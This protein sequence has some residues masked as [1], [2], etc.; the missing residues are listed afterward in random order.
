MVS[1]SPFMRNS[2]RIL[3]SFIC[4]LLLLGGEDNVNA[5]QTTSVAVYLPMVSKPAEKNWPMAAAN[6]ERTSW[7]PEEVRGN[8]KPLWYKPFKPYILPRV[9]IIAALGNL[10]VS[11]ARGLYALDADTGEEKWVYP[12]EL[13]LGHSPTIQD[14]I[15][16]VGGFDRKIYAINALTGEGLW[17]FQAGA[18]FDT[19]PLVVNGILYAG[20][21]D[22]FFY[23]IHING[24]DTGKL[25]WKFKTEGPIHFSAA[26]K[27]GTVYFASDDSYTYALDA[28]TGDLV[29]KSAK[30][31]GAGFHSWWP[32]VNGDYVIFAGSNNYRFSSD[33]G[34][35]S[36][37]SFEKTV[38]YP[39]GQTDP[40]GTL[41]GP[42]G[43]DSGAW[44]AGTPTI[45]T[46]K[47]ETTPNGAT[48][49][50][51]E[52]FEQFPWRRTYFVL[53]RLTGQ[54][55]T[56]DFD[57]DGK[58]EYAPILWYGVKGAGN[59]YPPIV[60]NDNILYQTNNYMSDPAIAGGQISG[61]QIGTPLISVITSDWGAI[62]EPEA[63]SAGGN[64]IYWNLCCDRQSG[65]IDISLPDTNFL[66][67]YNN[68]VRPPTGGIDSKR[69]GRYFTYNL[70]SIL[71]GYNIMYYG[72][73]GSSY[74][75]FGGKNGVY[76]YHGDQNPPIPYQGKVYMH[77][78]NAVIAFAPEAQNPIG[79]PPAEIK[80]V[81]SQSNPESLDQLQA[82]L[83]AEVE[84]IL[85]AGH[86]RPGYL[87]AG[88]FDLRGEFSC[89]DDLVDYWHNP[90][91]TIYTLIRALPHLPS[92]L[93]NETL[94]YI[95][96][97]FNQFPPYE[98]NHIGWKD[99]TAREIFDLP[100]EVEAARINY[101][102]KTRNPT[103]D[104]WGFA[105]QSFYALWKYAEIFGDAKNLFDLSKN[106]LEP[107]PPDKILME[108]PHVHNAFIA[109]YLGYLELEKLA[110]YPE[111][112]DIRDE[113]NRLLSLRATTFSTQA[114]DAYFNVLQKYYC[115]S[116]NASRNFMYLV[117]ELGQYLHDNALSKVQQAVDEYEYLTPY[118][119]V[120]KAEVAFGEGD[121]THLYDYN[122][123]FQARAL[124]LQEPYSELEK[125]IDVPAMPVGDLFYIQN[126]VSAI[127]AAPPP[128]TT[129]EESTVQPTY[130]HCG[131]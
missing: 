34:P 71:P 105:P 115:R 3:F 119:F 117:P 76:G 82:K 31:P 91:D 78:S 30:L 94:T 63:Y 21:R 43:T 52:Y 40:K 27:D 9:Q 29:W 64:L 6:P 96:S 129:S 79:L 104:A 74:A 7:T 61:W 8:L 99:G 41:V 5:V 28:Q 50:I 103:Y 124:I 1:Y 13:P 121:I 98:F 59:R 128:A 122:S 116:L 127:E 54:E 26:Y 70:D 65:S 81:Q 125:Y 109:G 58:L 49:P 88:I 80:P 110:G 113:L 12:T 17:T 87:S 33:L 85:E 123:V 18:G 84:K 73:D 95:Q 24:S 36:L 130:S 19:N 126:L 48:K 53:N 102:P 107:V 68:G 62:D 32:V 16:Y 92:N 118:W 60:G 101:G 22:G 83:I 45:N 97:E 112:T 93:Q 72:S 2:T 35:G 20:N 86:L 106:N 47:A 46:S 38:V 111:S 89:G 56:T 23:A 131:K 67:R 25:A 69:E 10:Y 51:T 57:G 4:V 39:N 42:M 44:V 77:R 37:P 55:Y 100:P 11:T 120:S 66:D 14:G 90:G 15:A 114:P 108:M 75:S